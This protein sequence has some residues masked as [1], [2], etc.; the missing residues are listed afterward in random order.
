MSG[1]LQLRVFGFP[2]RIQWSFLAV[3]TLLGWTPGVTA[4]RLAIWVVLAAVSITWHELGHAFAARRLGAEPSI[5]LYGF[6]GLTR[7]QPPADPSRLQMIGVSLA[8]PGAGMLLGLLVLAGVV[9]AG[10]TGSG[11]T[12]FFVLAAL[13]INLGWGLVNLLPVLP[14][15]G[16]HVMTELIPGDRPTRIRRAAIVSI[17]TGGIAAVA[18]VVV[19]FV[20]GALIFGWAVADNI[21]TL[22]AASR[23]RRR[24]QGLEEGA[25]ILDRVARREPGSLDEAVA[26]VE[27]M[28]PDELPFRIAAIETAAAAGE[29]RAVRALLDVPGQTPPGL[30][31]L[32]LVA[33]TGGIEGLEEM[34]SIYRREPTVFHARWLTIAMHRAGRMAELASVIAG[35]EVTP[36]ADVVAGAAELAAGLGHAEV[37]AALGPR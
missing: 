2:T 36:G 13:W 16:G 29:S 37:A 35:P 34:V 26:L 20:F 15:D 19:G 7:W 9:V 18:L 30:W 27:R 14:L 21:S 24:Q 31:A 25:A 33:E 6:G 10:G 17:L 5:D 3:I 23:A 11:D 28:R 4:S 1:G 12:R 32:V 22:N 8:G